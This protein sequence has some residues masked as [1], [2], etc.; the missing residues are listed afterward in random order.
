M[1]MSRTGVAR[2]AAFL[3]F[4]ACAAVR[5]QAADLRGIYV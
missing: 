3:F 1:W 2:G 4:L 5:V